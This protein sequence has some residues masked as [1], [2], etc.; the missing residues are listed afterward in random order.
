MV[1]NYSQGNTN[2]WYHSV[3][4]DQHVWLI[5]T[6]K[7]FFNEISYYLPVT[8]SIR[9]M[10]VHCSNHAK[11][12]QSVLHPLIYNT[13][14]F[15]SAKGNTISFGWPGWIININ[16]FDSGVSAIDLSRERA[17]LCAVSSEALYAFKTYTVALPPILPTLFA[18]LFVFKSQ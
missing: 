10:W 4:C 17:T 11:V 16:L 9:P 12:K 6:L 13:D 15:N 7:T 3:D 14:V 2:S 5:M 1:C 8:G 18:S